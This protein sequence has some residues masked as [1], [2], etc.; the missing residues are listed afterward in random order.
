MS[1]FTHISVQTQDFDFAYEYKKLRD[2]NNSDGALV[3]FVG[4]VRDINLQQSVSGLFL[5]HY[6]AM[7]EKVLN[8]I[9]E[10]ARAKWNL[11]SVSIIHRIG[12]LNVSEQIVFVGVTSQH[13]QSAYQANEFI[14][15]YLKTKAP[16]WKKETTAN[17]DNWIEAKASDMEKSHD[18][19]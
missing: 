4:L 6:P 8:N 7:T 5:E 13:R 19:S 18:W 1:H 14:M 9:V 3:T 12:Q 10:N 17:G 16:F 2:S 11:G 15:D